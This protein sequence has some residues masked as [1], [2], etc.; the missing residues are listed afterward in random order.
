MKKKEEIIVC[1][2]R[3]FRVVEELDS[4]KSLEEIEFEKWS[5]KSYCLKAVESDGDALR[6][7]KEQSEAICLK[8]VETCG[9][10][11][12]YVKERTIFL[13]ILKGGDGAD[14]SQS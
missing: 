9:Y 12:Q 14:S 13:K 3:R 5:D 11:L 4:G 7:V 8:A 10:A 6:Y 2:G 1:K